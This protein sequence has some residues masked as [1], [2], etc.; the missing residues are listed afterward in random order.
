MSVTG[1]WWWWPEP[2][3]TTPILEGTGTTDA[4]GVL[5][6]TLDGDVIADALE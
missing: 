3:D 1:A 4:N 5:E 6:I 2:V